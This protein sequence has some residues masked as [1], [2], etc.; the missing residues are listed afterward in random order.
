MDFDWDNTKE[1]HVRAERGFGFAEAITIFGGRVT[2]RQDTRHD[3]GEVRMIAVGQAD[4]IFYTVVYTDRGDVRHV[5][6]AWPS[7]RKERTA[8]LASA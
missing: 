4:G 2:E 5:I 6:T 7:N 1:A 8:W 3:Y